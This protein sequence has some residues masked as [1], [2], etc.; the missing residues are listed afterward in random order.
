MIYLTLSMSLN[1]SEPQSHHIYERL[2]LGYPEAFPGLTPEVYDYTEND[3]EKD[4]LGSR[5]RKI[6]S[7]S[8]FK[9]SFCWV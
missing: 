3:D 5:G 7:N 6:R 4:A 9:K 8:K 1:H 2:K